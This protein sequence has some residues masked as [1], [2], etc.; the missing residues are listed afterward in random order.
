MGFWKTI[1][2]PTLPTQFPVALLDLK[3]GGAL[4]SWFQTF[5]NMSSEAGKRR[6]CPLERSWQE[7]PNIGGMMF[8]KNSILI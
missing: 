6:R 3:S 8:S 4:P 5:E 1:P 2:L 7:L